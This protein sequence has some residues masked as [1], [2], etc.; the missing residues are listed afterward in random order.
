MIYLVISDQNAI[1]IEKNLNSQ[2]QNFSQK[3]K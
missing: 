2:N 3:V 1:S